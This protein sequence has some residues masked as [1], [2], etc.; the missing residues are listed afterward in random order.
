MLGT[1]IFEGGSEEDCLRLLV[2][3]L[4]SSTTGQVDQVAPSFTLPLSPY[5]ARVLA[6]LARERGFDGYLLNFECPLG[7]GLEQTRALAAWITLLQSEIREKVGP[8][9]ETLWYDSVVINGQLA[10]QD[11]LNSYNLPF[12]LSSSGLF[13]NYTWR[14]EYPALTAQYFLSLEQALIGNTK[15]TDSQIVPKT[16]RDIYMGIDVWGRGSHGGGGLGSYKALTHISPESLGLSVAI[17]GQAWSWESEQD[18]EGWCWDHWWEFDTRL[19]VG[20]VSGTVEVP[21][22]PKRKGEPDCVHGPFLPITT[23]FP[24]RPPPDPSDLRFHTT[25]CP[26]TGLH[27]LWKVSKFTKARMAG[28]MSTSKR[29]LAICCGLV[30]SFTG[31]TSEKTRYQ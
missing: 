21:E 26:G 15:E 5:Y 30:R 27:G 22:A 25:F 13:S 24:R 2:G 28:Q 1:L 17:F 3:K 11:R 8:H 20:P 9:G 18:K 4:P 29:V 31:K 7:G 23:F 12:F 6:D 19:W 10:W 16:L 14:N